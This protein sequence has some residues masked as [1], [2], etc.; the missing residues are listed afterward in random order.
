MELRLIKPGMT[1][2]NDQA[3]DFQP[4]DTVRKSKVFPQKL[5]IEVKTLKAEPKGKRLN[6][7]RNHIKE[8]SASPE[9]SE[10][11][12]EVGFFEEKSDPWP[13]T[14]FY[15]DLYIYPESVALRL[16]SEAT[17]QVCKYFYRSTTVFSHIPERD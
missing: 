10:L 14:T 1:V 11:V 9:D 3:Y 12:Q 2:T 16:P 5:T 13:H 7:S 15:N 6:S 4:N 17:I 8:E